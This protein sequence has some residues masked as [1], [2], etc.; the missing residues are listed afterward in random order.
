MIRLRA[1]LA[2]ALAIGA[3]VAAASPLS[4][5]D[6][7]QPTPGEYGRAAKLASVMFESANKQIRFEYPK[8]DWEIVPRANAAPVPGASS[9]VVS[10]VQKKREAAVVVEQTKLHQSLA[11]DDI[12]DLL[13]Q[14]EMESVRERQ[15][16]ASDVKARLVEAGGRRFVILTYARQGVSGPE[17]VR[18]YSFAAGVD[19][20]RLTCF[21]AASQFTR[22]EPVF[23]HVAASF[24]VTAG[25]TQ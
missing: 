9:P 3:S 24:T 25:A 21:A 1:C 6:P 17:R 2:A 4:A 10:L 12:T 18:Q 13:G 14:L 16:Q 23:A 15:P 19:L 20:F 22:Y 5:Q 7:V 8:R 11:P